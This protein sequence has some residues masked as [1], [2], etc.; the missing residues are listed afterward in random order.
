MDADNERLKRVR[1]KKEHAEWWER[2]I[3]RHERKLKSEARHQARLEENKRLVSDI[4]FKEEEQQPNETDNDGENRSL[5][6]EKTKDQTIKQLTEELAEKDEQIRQ[7]H[8]QIQQ[9]QLFINSMAQ[10]SSK[11][12]K[13]GET[14][15]SRP[16]KSRVQM[17]SVELLQVPSVAAPC[18]SSAPER[19]GIRR[20]KVIM[21]GDSGVGKTSIVLSYRSV[22]NNVHVQLQLWDTAGQERFRGMVPQYT[23]N[24]SAAILVYDI[25]SRDSFEQIDEWYSAAMIGCSDVD[26]L[27]IVLIGNKAD[28]N[29]LRE[30][31]EGEGVSKALRLKGHFF[32]LS[33]YDTEVIRNIFILVAEKF[34]HKCANAESSREAD[35]T[36]PVIRLGNGGLP[37]SSRCCS[38]L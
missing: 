10:S 1:L 9:Q 2:Q 21:L 11:S 22:F 37:G 25:T 8:E 3:E 38:A 34:V 16:R 29:N 32:E 23:R 27:T 4:F 14:R 30:V 7:Q 12:G 31:A 6:E 28:Q 35:E 13:F 20:S 26:E 36:S 24:A 5:N 17:P 18:G 33:V 15:P 19:L